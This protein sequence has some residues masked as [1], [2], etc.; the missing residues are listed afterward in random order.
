M[1]SILRAAAVALVLVAVVGA[2]QLQQASIKV[3]YVNTQAIMDVAPGRAG[4]DSAYQ[5]E[6]DA[7]SAQFKK[8]SDSL[9][10]AIAAFQKKEPTLTQAQKDA[11]TKKLG[12]FQTE[13]QGTQLKF[14]QQLAQKQNELFA[15]VL[16]KVKKVLE[17]IRT[18]DGYAVIF[19]NDPGQSVIVA[20]D[21]NL[22]ITERVVARLKTIKAGPGNPAGVTR[23]P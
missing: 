10:A 21:K 17:D 12:T 13:V 2:T 5:R 18:E 22:D 8:M 23:K 14:Q 16:E 9:A 20:A 6:S 3:A 15:P 1:R 7:L 4:A 19:S 11:E